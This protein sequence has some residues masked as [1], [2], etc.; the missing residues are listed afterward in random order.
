METGDFVANKQHKTVI[1][2]YPNKVKTRGDFSTIRCLSC[3]RTWESIMP[4][5]CKCI[6]NLFFSFSAILYTYEVNV[7]MNIG[8]APMEWVSDLEDS[9]S[10][11][12]KSY[13]E[14]LC[15]FVSFFSHY[16][17][18]LRQERLLGGSP[19]PNAPTHSVDLFGS[20]SWSR[21]RTRVLF[22][23]SMAVTEHKN[24]LRISH[25]A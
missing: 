16:N 24:E 7:Q 25:F 18:R 17:V 21:L 1:T 12:Y 14:S 11:T 2:E 23:L 10:Y 20:L 4:S 8:G 19:P 5:P 15:N 6:S 9:N 13:S 3:I 22:I